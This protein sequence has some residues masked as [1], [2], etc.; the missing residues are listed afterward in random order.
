MRQ[1]RAILLDSLKQA[2]DCG[3][4]LALEPQPRVLITQHIH[5]VVLPA[6]VTAQIE[7]T[8]LDRNAEQRN[9]YNQKKSGSETEEHEE[10]PSAENRQQPTGLMPNG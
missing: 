5:P 1:F 6:E 2:I 10:S 9:Q 7:I 8:F 3:E 4:L